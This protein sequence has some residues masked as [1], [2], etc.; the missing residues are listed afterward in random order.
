MT[1]INNPMKEILVDKVTVNV[2]VGS[3]GE[4]LDGIKTFME[5]LIGVKFVE[6]KAR[7]RNPVFKLRVGLPIGIK[8]TLRG[9]RALEFLNRALDSKKR[10]LDYKNFDATGNFAFG[11]AECIDVPGSKYDP[12]VGVFGF[13]V[14]VTLKKRGKRVAERMKNSGKIKIVQLV[15]KE[16]AIDFAK[17]K[18]GAKFDE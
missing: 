5:K 17:T 4:R 13:D 9:K 14:C 12:K 1:T 10:K 18:F 8:T 16:E 6:T 2:G 7:K 11:V 3:P 15:K